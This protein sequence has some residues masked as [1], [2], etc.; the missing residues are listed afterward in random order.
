MFNKSWG[1]IVFHSVF[2]VINLSS[3]LILIKY[4]QNTYIYDNFWY[5]TLLSILL[6]PIY[7]A[8]FCLKS[9]RTR[10]KTY[11]IALI[12]PLLAGFIYT[13]ESVLLYYSVNNLS[14]S[15]YTILRSSF[16]I[17][18]IPFFYFL[19][20]KKISKI[21]Y[22]GTLFLLLSYSAIIYYY[23]KTTNELLQPTISIM[24]SCLLNTTYNILIEY[25]IKKYNIYNLDFQVLFQISYFC[26]AIIP[27]LKMTLENAPP[28]NIQI[29]ILSLIISICLQ[30]YFYN[31]IFILENNNDFVPS[32][33]LMSGLDLIRRLVLLLFSFFMFNDEFNIYIGFSVVFFLG[34]GVCMFLEYFIPL[35]KPK[36]DYSEMI[37][38]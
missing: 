24:I 33:V 13:F 16:V 30:F 17:W 11:G 4:L 19:L 6:T 37:D 14:L 10:M 23:L 36:K 18:N 29:M 22:F 28:I 2:Y 32:N 8:F 35:K 31:K 20:K 25:S 38:I 27:S 21:Y 9:V 1:S 3:Y 34:S 5:N 12:F 26:F 7:F 15:Y